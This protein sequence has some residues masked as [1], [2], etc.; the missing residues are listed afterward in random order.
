MLIPG[1]IPGFVFY[2]VLSICCVYC[3]LVVKLYFLSSAVHQLAQPLEVTGMGRDDAGV[4][5][6]RLDDHAR[7]LSGMLFEHALDRGA[8]VSRGT[9][10]FS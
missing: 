7:D 3:L 1:P 5:H 6:H 9:T 4:H 8:P 10:P 2:I